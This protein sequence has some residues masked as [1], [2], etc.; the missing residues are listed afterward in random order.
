MEKINFQNLPNT[1]TPVN[2]SNLNQLQDNVEN[3]LITKLKVVASENLISGQS[4]TYSLPYTTSTLYFIITHANGGN[5]AGIYLT[6]QLSN[7]TFYSTTIKE[8]TYTTVTLSQ[9][10]VAI[11]STYTTHVT[12]LEL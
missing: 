3:D 11:S 10:S 8:P 7:G 2:A 1:T 5:S 12:I 9:G 6:F 4:K